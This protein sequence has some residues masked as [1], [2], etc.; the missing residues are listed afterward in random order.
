VTRRMRKIQYDG[1]TNDCHV[2]PKFIS[3]SN[4][5]SGIRRSGTSRTSN[6]R[7]K[8]AGRSIILKDFSGGISGI[9]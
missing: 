4:W 3:S 9:Q 1:T 2:A 6:N 5:D 7:V 8:G